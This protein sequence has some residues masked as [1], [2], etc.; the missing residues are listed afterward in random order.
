MQKITKKEAREKYGIVTSG[1]SSLCS[2]YLR[3]DGCIV[4]DSGAV[5]YA[6]PPKKI[7]YSELASLFRARERENEKIPFAERQHLTGCIVFTE[8]SFDEPYSLES[9][10]Y[11]V[12]SDNKAFIPNMGGYSIFGSAIDGSDPGVRLEAYMAEERG[13]ASGWRVDYCYLA[14]EDA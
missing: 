4:D 5:R 11:A 13:G 14:E 3:D 7:T 9:R 6:P 1:A 10:T 2:F 12:S 8:D